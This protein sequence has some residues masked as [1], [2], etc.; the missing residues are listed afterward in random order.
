MRLAF[1]L[2]IMHYTQISKL[3]S[4][5]RN[6]IVG[7]LRGYHSNMS[8]SLEQLE[9]D[10]IDT[11]LQILKEYSLQGVLPVKDLYVTINCIPVDCKDLERC[12]CIS[13]DP[14]FSTPVAHFEIP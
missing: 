1:F 3:A 12:S 13:N 4:A 6:D 11:R 5:I 8:M 7:G 2:Y 10:I 9:D 14:C